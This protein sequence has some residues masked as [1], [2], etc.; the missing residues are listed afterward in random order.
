MGPSMSID[1]VSL[2]LASPCGK[3]TC[4]NGA[5][6]SIDGVGGI[7]FRRDSEDFASQ[8]RAEGSFLADWDK[9]IG[10]LLDNR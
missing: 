7:K 1:G 5:S 3:S 6:M 2:Q 4:F 10:I 9:A 8:V